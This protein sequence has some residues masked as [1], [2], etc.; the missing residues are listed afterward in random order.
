MFHPVAETLKSNA[1]RNVAARVLMTRLKFDNLRKRIP[2][3]APDS[4]I[5]INYPVLYRK[6]RGYRYNPEHLP[7]TLAPPAN[8]GLAIA[9]Y[10]AAA[11]ADELA[12]AVARLREL[13]E[14][15]EEPS[16]YLAGFTLGCEARATGDIDL[17]LRT[18]ARTTTILGFP[19]YKRAAGEF[20]GTFITAKEHAFAAVNR[21]IKPAKRGGALGALA[22]PSIGGS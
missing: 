22:D 11:T 17:D 13:S 15:L 12:V 6:A 18:A 20:S 7:N 19:A 9:A 16:A 21:A 10:E 4:G 2:V 5:A 8:V 14:V 3:K 1:A